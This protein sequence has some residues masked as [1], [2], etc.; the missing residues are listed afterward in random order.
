M[1]ETC[2]IE[3]RDN[4]GSIFDFPTNKKRSFP[5]AFI[6]TFCNKRVKAT[7]QHLTQTHTHALMRAHTPMVQMVEGF[8]PGSL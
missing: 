3:A 1:E 4:R 6:L 7:G 8:Y 5:G 2:L